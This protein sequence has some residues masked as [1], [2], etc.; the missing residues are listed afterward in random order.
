MPATIAEKPLVNKRTGRNQRKRVY[1]LKIGC[2]STIT[3]PNKKQI[4]MN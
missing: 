4:A 1:V 2:T 3:E